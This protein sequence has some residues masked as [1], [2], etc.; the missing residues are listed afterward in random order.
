MRRAAFAHGVQASCPMMILTLCLLHGC[1]N[2]PKQQVKPVPARPAEAPDVFRVKLE[3]SK[4]SFVIQVHK[5]WAPRG[6]RRFYDLVTSGFYDGARFYRVVRN[7][8]AQFGYK[9]DPKTDSLWQLSYIADDPARQSNKKGF[10]S[11]AQLGPATRTT[12]VFINLRDNKDLDKSNF[13]P[14]GQVVEGMEVAG[15]LTYSYGDLSPRGGGPDP[16]QI[17]LQGNRY[18]ESK[19]PRLDYIVRATVLPAQ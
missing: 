10:V 15:K 8:I 12:Q 19:F 7:Y 1:D 14:F 3:T 9:G 16:K 18:L 17:A 2:P 6:A 13:V 5:E 11:F 4:G